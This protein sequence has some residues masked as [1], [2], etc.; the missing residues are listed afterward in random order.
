MQ[1]I[2]LVFHIIACIALIVLI[3]MQQGKGAEAG[4]AFG[5]G[6]SQTVFGSRGAGTFLIKITGTLAALFFA[7][8]ILLNYLSSH[9]NDRNTLE[10]LL[11]ATAAEIPFDKT[12]NKLQ[13]NISSPSSSA[14]LQDEQSEPK[15]DNDVKT[16]EDNSKEKE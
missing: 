12:L 6:A 4:A 15:A 11:P 16:R 9:H 8:S 3:V 2:I 10:S 7:T 13:E 14:L 1:Q 5:S